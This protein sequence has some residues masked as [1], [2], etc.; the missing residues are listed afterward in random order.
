MPH[1]WFQV[2]G[3][4]PDNLGA[5]VI[6]VHRVDVEPVEDHSSWLDTSFLVVVGADAAVDVCARRRFSQVVTHRS[7]HQRDLLR[8]RKTTGPSGGLVY[9]Q[10]VV[11]PHV[12]LGV[13]LRLLLAPDQRG[14]TGEEPFD[15]TQL[16]RQLEADRGSRRL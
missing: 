2:M 12:S 6:A 5:D 8:I 9:H 13:P 4:E 14:Q 1:S 11:D 15:D 7:Q 16:Q 3:D 10:E